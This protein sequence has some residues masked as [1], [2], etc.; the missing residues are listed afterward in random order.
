MKRLKV[1][2][3]VSTCLNGYLLQS[4]KIGSPLSLFLCIIFSVE[5][6][7]WKPPTNRKRLELNALVHIFCVRTMQIIS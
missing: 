7:I 6:A 2:M 5:Y 3:Y 1:S 4:A